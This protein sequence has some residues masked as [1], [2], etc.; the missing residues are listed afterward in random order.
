MNEQLASSPDDNRF[1][2]NLNFGACCRLEAFAFLVLLSQI[3]PGN[4]SLQSV[5]NLPKHIV[6]CEQEIGKYYLSGKGSECYVWIGSKL[7]I[8]GV[9]LYISNGALFNKIGMRLYES[10]NAIKGVGTKKV[11]A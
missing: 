2:K 4:F 8:R 11:D 7:R 5:L 3:L 6:K 10:W 1:E 9:Q